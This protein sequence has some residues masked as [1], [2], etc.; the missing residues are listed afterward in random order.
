M[1]RGARPI[2]PMQREGLAIVLRALEEREDPIPKS[3]IAAALGLS[4]KA[5][6]AW[7]RIRAFA[8]A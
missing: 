5:V 6:S 3:H 4:R 2:T 7:R 1:P 8:A